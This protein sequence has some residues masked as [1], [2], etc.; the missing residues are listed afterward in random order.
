MKSVLFL[1][2]FTTLSFNVSAADLKVQPPPTGIYHCAFPNFGGSE[3]RVTTK[4]MTDFRKLARKSFGWAYFSNN[5]FDGIL[6]PSDSVSTIDNS[7]RIPFIRMMPRSNWHE[8]QPDPVYT[9]QN[10]IDGDFDAALTQWALDAKATNIPLMVEFGTEVNGA[11]FPW[12][13]EWNG[14]STTD[15]YGDPVLADGPERFRDAYRHIIDLFRANAA[16][17][18][19]WV[20]H[21]DAA[22]EPA[23]SW[24]SMAAY[25]P[26]DDYIDWIGISVYGAQAPSE[27]WTNFTEVLDPAYVE[28]TSISAT[29]PAALLEFGVTEGHPNGNKANWIT[30]A[31]RAVRNGRYPRISAISWWHSK[32]RNGDGSISDLRIDSSPEALDAYRKAVADPMFV[33]QIVVQ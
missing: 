15:G 26:G 33:S 7:G 3:D 2:F 29:K 13:G 12:N 28:F 16:D 21:V 23:D 18:I 10:I 25:Y 4:R 11:W 32:W 8:Y 30:H 14:G 17:N 9:M 24:N 1:F 22:G 6:F 31:F 20:F 19:T 27:D 5:W